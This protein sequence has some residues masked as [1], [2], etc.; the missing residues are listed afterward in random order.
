MPEDP[1][2][3]LTRHLTEGLPEFENAVHLDRTRIM[4]SGQKEWY[5]ACLALDDDY[6]AKRVKSDLLMMMAYKGRR[7]DDVV[8]AMGAL[9][10]SEKI[11]TGVQPVEQ[12]LRE[13]YKT[14]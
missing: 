10:E 7:S 13:R 1:K 11:A 9:K 12:H 5:H 3:K 4:F 8:S 14:E 6:F 2:M